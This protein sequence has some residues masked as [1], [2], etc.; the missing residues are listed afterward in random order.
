MP[1]PGAGLPYISSAGEM[2]EKASG[3]AWPGRTR[4]VAVAVGRPI[5]PI[6][7]GGRAGEGGHTER[8]K[9]SARRPSHTRSV[10]EAEFVLHVFQFE[11]SQ[12]RTTARK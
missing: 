2:S 3:Q 10:E 7:L 11:I 9:P 6:L 8:E 4:S 1:L 12:S 5:N